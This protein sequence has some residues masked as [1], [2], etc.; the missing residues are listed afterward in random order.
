MNNVVGAAEIL[1]RPPNSDLGSVC[2]PKS[3]FGDSHTYLARSPSA[4]SH[5]DVPVR[6]H[7][8]RNRTRT[9]PGAGCVLDMRH[10]RRLSAT[11]PAGMPFGDPPKPR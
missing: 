8:A 1:P 11:P 5:D 4:V 3:E 6:A 9:A 7:V 10:I 2:A